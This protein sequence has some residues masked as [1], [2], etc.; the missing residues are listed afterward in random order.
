MRLDGLLE[1]FGSQAGVARALGVSRQ[2]VC[3]WFALDALPPR[4]AL[5]IE[6]ITFGAFKAL[7]LIDVDLLWEGEQ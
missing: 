4:R 3:V 7:D 6:R 1:R 2:S 5:E